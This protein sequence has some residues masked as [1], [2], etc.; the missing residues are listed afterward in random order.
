MKHTT[1][2]A[3]SLALAAIT[4]LAAC[5]NNDSKAADQS[6]MEAKAT[7]INKTCP[8]SGEAAKADVTSTCDGKTVAF[9]CAGCKGKFDKMDHAAQAKMVS[10]AK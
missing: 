5:A 7:P 8:L 10:A 3:L 1:R 6:K 9:C 4:G 2:I